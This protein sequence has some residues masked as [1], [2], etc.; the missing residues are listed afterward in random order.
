MSWRQ[1][2]LAL[3]LHTAEEIETVRFGLYWAESARKIF[4]KGDLSAYW[5]GISFEG[6]FLGA[7]P[8]YTHIRDPMLRLCHRLIV[9]SIVGRSQA[10]GK[11]TVTDLFYLKGMD[12]G[13]VNIPCLLARYLRMFASRRKRWAMISRGFLFF[14]HFIGFY[15]AKSR[16]CEE[17]DDTWAWVASR[18][19]R[20]PD[21]A[22]GAPE[23]A[24]GA[25]DV[26]EGARAVPAPVQA[27]QLPLAAE[28]TRTMA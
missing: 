4:D 24:E 3:G 9:C 21:A 2:I 7:P 23:V 1:F 19:E 17:L 5:R 10:P 25:P 8:F 6:D 15:L 14:W 22:A 27:P 20:Q 28:P 13:S 18:L 26:D 11:V 16:I 12:V